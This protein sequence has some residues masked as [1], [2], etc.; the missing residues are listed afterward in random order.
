LDSDQDLQAV[1][2]LDL[3]SGIGGFSLGLERAGMETVAFCEFDKKAR[4]VLKKHWPDIPIFEDIKELNYDRLKHLSAIDLICG[5]FPCQPWS[6]AGKSG[7]DQDDR[8]LWPE[9]FRVITEVR[10]RW[11][12]GENVPG[13]AQHE[14][15]L[16]R[17]ISD[18]EGEGYETQTFNIP[19]CAKG[20]PHE[21]QRL[22]IVAHSIRSS[23]R[24]DGRETGESEEVQGKYWA[25]GCS[26]LPGR[27]SISSR[28]VAN[29]IGSD[30]GGRADAG[31]LDNE[32]RE[33]GKT[34]GESLH[35]GNGEA[36]S[37]NLEP[38]CEN[39]SHSDQTGPQ[40]RVREELP[41][42]PEQRPSR[43]RDTQTHEDY[44][45][46]KPGMGLLVD[47]ISRGL[48]SHWAL[49]PAHIPRTINRLPGQKYF[50]RVDRLKQL[51]NAVVPQIVEMLGRAIMEA[52][53]EL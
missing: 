1:R 8:D 43:S 4:L 53:K 31:Y 10:P 27:T 7:G 5:G 42:C 38:S 13:F 17:T 28:N 51:G 37:D 52:E 47:G 3:F 50:G 40:R 19:A 33:L 9:M 15:G 48:E 49:E 41:E 18:L 6:V 24:T 34:G 29:S 45:I 25:Q 2:V 12:I 14:M 21:R 11:V 26:G 44:G 39:V 30:G 16:K 32:R 22:W 36:C 35:P 23:D 46:V 20:A